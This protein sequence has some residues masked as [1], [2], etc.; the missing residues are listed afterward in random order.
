MFALPQYGGRQVRA[1]HLLSVGR[2]IREWLDWLARLNWPQ[3]L[4]HEMFDHSVTDKGRHAV[5]TCG[6][7]Y[8]LPWNRHIFIKRELVPTYSRRF[9]YSTPLPNMVV[10]NEI[11][12]RL[13]LITGASGG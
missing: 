11:K 5:S 13:A 8:L 3:E 1:R 9:S 2:L 12:G 6:A 10:D 7:P 4:L